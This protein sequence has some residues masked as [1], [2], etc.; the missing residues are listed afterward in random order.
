MAIFVRNEYYSTVTFFQAF[1]LAFTIF[2]FSFPDLISQ[3]TGGGY[4]ESYITRNVGARPIAMGGA[5]T[6][7]VNDPFALYYNPAGVGFFG[8]KPLV[9]SSYSILGL[10]R[11]HVS[12]AYG[13]QLKDNFGI[14][15]AFTMLHSGSFMARDIRGNP[16][17]EMTAM[18][19]NFAIAGAFNTE[20]MSM[21]ASVK[22]LGS[23]LSGSPYASKGFALDVGTK[24]D[25][26]GLFSVGIAMQ[27]IAGMMFWD[28]SSVDHENL[29]YVIRTGI[30]MEYGFNDETYETRST[31]TGEVEK[32]SVPATR[33]LLFSADAVYVQHEKSPNFIVGIEY[34][35]HEIIAFRGGISVY[36]DKYGEPQLFPMNYW[37][38]GFSIRP[39]IQNLPFNLN[40][41]YSVSKE[42]IAESGISH[43]IS[44]LFQF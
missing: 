43:N 27:N 29:P 25:V 2:L 23:N 4:P 14:G 31:V 16:L 34:S 19:Y 11:N 41:D 15:A 36:G 42:I 35:A 1:L 3:N 21:G 13:Q 17:G 37:G 10:D 44:L 28:N 6:A 38:A 30:A 20:F 33:Y 9:S 7:V 18:Q 39:Q 24:F 22:Y 12:L 5:Y 26:M 8:N 40:V 32:V